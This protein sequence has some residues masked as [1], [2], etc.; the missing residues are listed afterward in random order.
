MQLSDSPDKITLEF[1]ADGDKNT[2]PVASSPTPG[3]ASFEDGFPPITRTPLG[4][5]GIPPFGLDMNGILFDLSAISRWMN[6]GAGFVY[7]GTF[8]A[9]SDVGGYPK[10]SELVCSD[11]VGS[12]LNISDNNAADPDAGGSG[13]VP[14]VRYGSATIAV[15]NSNVTLTAEQYRKPI[16]IMTGVLTA[17]INLIFPELIS[18][19][20]IDNRTTGSFSVT[21]KTASGTGVIIPTTA[22]IWGDG[23]NLYLSALDSNFSMADICTH[24]TGTNNALVAIFPNISPTVYTD[25]IPFYVRAA[26]ANT[27]DNPTMTF[28]PGVLAPK[29]LVK[30]NAQPL[31][32]GSNGGIA[33]AGHWLCVQYDSTLDKIVLANPAQIAPLISVSTLEQSYSRLTNLYTFTNPLGVVPKSAQLVF[34]CTS[35]DGGFSPGDIVLLPASQ[36]QQTTVAAWGYVTKFTTTQVLLSIDTDDG[37]LIHKWDGDGSFEPATGKWT[38]GYYIIG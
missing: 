21:C 9:D 5:G 17:N 2:I 4:S 14:G 7:D 27:V 35:A 23:V 26:G 11:G 24:A 28:N 31:G 37:M 32:I 1:A 36:S 8:A 34:I 13:W 22:P 10:G 29:T 20:V 33:G 16:I 25:G 15:S 3:R 18:Q 30:Y 19:W 38:L 6:A 12:W